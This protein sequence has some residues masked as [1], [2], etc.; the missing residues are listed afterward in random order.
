MYDFTNLVRITFYELVQ[1][2]SEKNYDLNELTKLKNE[3]CNLISEAGISRKAIESFADLPPL[4]PEI[5]RELEKLYERILT[6]KPCKDDVN[7]PS[8]I[9]EIM[10]TA[11]GLT[12]ELPPPGSDLL[13]RIYGSWLGRCAG[14]LLGKPVEGWSHDKIEKY[15]KT[16]GEYPLAYYFPKP[17][18]GEWGELIPESRRAFREYIDHMLRDDDIDYMILNLMVLEEYGRTFTSKDVASSWLTH[19]PYWATYTAERVAYKNF[20]NN[21]WPPESGEYQNPY[22]EWIGAQI[23]GDI[24]GLV[25]PG[26]PQAAA[27][28]AYKDAIISHR[29]NGIYGEMFVSAALA[30]ALVLHAD[31]LESVVKAGL[32]VIP[33]YSR[34]A[35]ALRE[36]MSWAI[37]TNDWQTT[38][39]RVE[40]EFGNYHPVHT[41]INAAI[42]VLALIHGEGNFEKS[43]TIAVMCGYDTDCN[44]ATVGS[45]VGALCGAQRLPHK[46][47][48]PLHDRVESYIVGNSNDRISNLANRTL[49]LVQSR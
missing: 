34:L 7:E 41:I 18:S 26:N 43:I 46:W 20:V 38:L 39:A 4:T 31:D 13:D 8:E 9:A 32:A 15:L 1:K 40:K 3:F 42:V 28:M 19:L 23:R 30:A 5:E 33:E 2:E 29:K 17:K 25:N 22:R 24:F 12:E 36:T 48:G 49:K 16:A 6:L 21:I 45:I 11:P 14:C 44:G 27:E 47:I 10:K 35:S 37:E